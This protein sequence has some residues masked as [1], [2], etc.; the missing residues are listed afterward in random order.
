M[1]TKC[2]NLLDKQ[3][4]VKVLTSIIKYI[5]DY[6][7]YPILNEEQTEIIGNNK[8][9]FAEYL[10]QEFNLTTCIILSV[11]TLKENFINNRM[12]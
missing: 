2:I 9:E 3:C 8:K 6:S 10:E 4:L 11:I 1:Q 7:S 5:V 12:D